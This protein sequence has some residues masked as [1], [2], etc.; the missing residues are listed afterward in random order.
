MTHHRVSL[1][2]VAALA[3]LVWAVGCGDGATEPPAPPPDPP[4]PTTVTVSPSTAELTAVGATVQLTVEVRDQNGNAMTGATVTWASG[5]PAVATVSSAGLVTA[6]GNGTATITATAG[7]AS[8]TAT[9]TVAQEVSAVAVSPAADTLVAG[10]TL[11]L[12]AVAADAN[13]HPVAEAGL[14]WASSDTLVAVVDAAGLVTGVGEG[15]AEVTA[16][17]AGVAGRAELVV[18]APVPA[19]VSVTPDTVSL[20]ALGQ[21]AQLAAEVRDQIG[22]VMDD[23]RVSWSTADTAVAAVDSAGLV[24][25]AGRG[26]TII[27]A[28]ADSAT[29]ASWVTVM[30]SAGSVVVSPAADTVA[31]GDTL[32]LAAE[33]FDENG[34]RV[35]GAEFSW[36][37]S[38]GSVATVD[39]SGLVTGLAEGTATITATAGSASDTSQ[40]TVE[41][42]DRAALVALYEATDGPNWVDNTNWLTNAPLGMWYGV[43]TDRRGRVDALHLFENNL[44]GSIPPG[45]GDLSRLTALDLWG[46]RID[47]VSGLANLTTLQRLSI[48][49]NNITDISPL[50][51]LTNLTKLSVGEGP[52]S[53]LSPLSGL[54]KLRELKV[55]G[56]DDPDLSLLSSLTNLSK[57]AL[58]HGNIV[59]ISALSDLT[60]LT[61]L[62]LWENQIENISALRDLSNLTFLSLSK[63]SI[64]D[65]SALASLPGLTDLYLTDNHITDV[66]PLSG[67]TN[68]TFLDLAFNNIVDI[69]PL[70]GLANLTSLNLAANSIAD[71]S[72]L[73]GLTNL[74][75]LDLRGNPYETL[76]EGD[77]DIELVLLDKFSES[78]ERMLDY[79]ARRWIAVV[80][81]DLPDYEFSEGWS[82]TCGR[83]SIEIS[84]GDRVDD[85]RVYVKK[86]RL[87]VGTLGFGG[88]IFV[89]EATHL[90]VLGCMGLDLSH[91]NLLTTGLHE[92]GHVLGIGSLWTTLGYFQ[93]PPDGDQHFNGPLAIAA[94]DAAGGRD[95]A[96]AKVPVVGG[97]WRGGVLGNELMTPTGTG[98]I[99]AISVQSLADLGYIVDVTQADPY[100]L[101]GN[102]RASTADAVA[103]PAVPQDGRA[104]GRLIFSAQERPR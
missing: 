32:R 61:G 87:S 53:D 59:D 37:S 92:L 28:T 77:F 8:G 58:S 63:N 94:F 80:T 17:A 74:E 3:G 96:G 31:L 68:L 49:Q 95:Y 38:N 20:T 50:A 99:S 5:A 48:S 9:V 21:T 57:L 36:S 12:S 4:R 84:A 15:E 45:F 98:A 52:I 82:G 39:G 90:P 40:I 13:G 29:G 67:L 104:T 30:Q 7:P 11:R 101:P 42:P 76:P 78:E 47:D 1:L 23:V 71:I 85:L 62:W 43:R 79:V 83:E 26:T 75:H 14:S 27:A 93:N 73:A 44:T 103:V 97:H 22:R 25:A 65:I 102:A 89:R 55:F 10:D 33:A 70:A 66:S 16:T 54:S 35:E 91:A 46:N 88:P 69:S 86:E 72:P 51:G 24:T 56:T 60:G 18:M 41:N 19:T 6:A 100:T 64:T 81:A 34:H 2:A